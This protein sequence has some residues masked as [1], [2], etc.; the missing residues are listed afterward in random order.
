MATTITANG[1]NFPDGS[2]A[3]PSIG[4]TDTNTGLFTGSDIV[5][6]ATGG[7]ERIKIDAQGDIF[8]GTT[9]D[10]APAN[11]TN[12]CVSDGTISRLI[13]EKQSTIKFG[14]N[15]S[16]GFTI[17][18]ETNDA[19]RF[20]IISDGKVGIGTTSPTQKLDVAGSLQ[21]GNGNAI[22]FGDQ[23]AR[24]IGES[25]ASG[26]LRFDVNG[27]ER[28]RISSTG[29][30]LIGTTS[31]TYN[32]GDIQHEIKKNNNRAYTAP[33][34]TS[35]SHLLLNNSDTTDKAFT[36]LGFRAGSGDGSIGYVY[37]NSANSADFVINTDGNANG[38]ERLRVFNGGTVLIGSLA[39]EAA[40]GSSSTGSARLVI[41][42]EGLNVFDDAADAVHYGLIFANDPTSNKAN[43]IGFF[44]DGGT[45]CGGYI[46]HQDKGS[47][48]IGDL[49]FGTSAA[50]DTPVEKLRITSD[51]R[52]L[53]NSTSV[54]KSHDALTVKR[55][56]GNH[57]A[58]S[59]T[60]DSTTATGSYANALIFTKSKDY[61]YNG[62]VFE[63][64]TGHQ[65]GVV[66]KMTAGGGTTPQIELRIGGTSLNQS[67]KSALTIYPSGNVSLPDGNLDFASGHGI[68]FSATANASG[69][70]S[71][72]LADYEHGTWDPAPN[73]SN[74][75]WNNKDG[76]YV[77][78]GS[79]V[80]CDMWLR[81]SGTSSSTSQVICSLPFA[82]C[83]ESNT[84]AR[85]TTAV[86]RVY[87]LR[88]WGSNG[89]A[90]GWVGAGSSNLNFMWN[91]NGANPGELSMNVWQSGAEIHASITYRTNV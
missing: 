23:S 90:F 40:G 57:S 7:V 82:A 50:A 75:S 25:G 6:F 3:A 2:A 20:S 73:T 1:I 15:V 85:P 91:N 55:A 14:L 74:P 43:G 56:A 64:S 9:S 72:L 32:S 77:R 34:M 59:L 24:I 4:G 17:Y 63:S 58:T 76:T 70:T 62:L 88:N 86:G 11:G 18:D 69:M 8:I 61:Y 44:N 80:H 83:D 38:V 45:A 48:N 41:D 46:V 87:N 39:N 12:L 27:G 71:E 81:A 16:T 29:A 36:G 31:A 5:G 28:L 35:H 68:D 53:V 60:V 37:R 89:N 49:V 78:I 30:L 84:N 10:I 65:G 51:G 33:L 22:G 21:L 42:C 67:D 13:L 66:A 54:V 52:V 47:N 26:I 79:L 19:A